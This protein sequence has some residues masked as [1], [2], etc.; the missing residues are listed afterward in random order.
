MVEQHE[1]PIILLDVHLPD[2]IGYEVCKQIKQ[3]WPSIMIL[4]TS[5]TFTTSYDRIYAL[6]SGADSFLAQ[7]AEPLELTAAINALLRIR[8]TEGELRGLNET[9]EHR[10]QDRIAELAEANEKLTS[11][12]A[13][14]QEAEEGIWPTLS[15]HHPAD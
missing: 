4:M 5:A 6:E 15:R 12:I 10:V 2:I 8:R 14:R 3:R 13:Q 11:E 7:P 9:L 1:P